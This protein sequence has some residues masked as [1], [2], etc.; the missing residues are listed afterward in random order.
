[1]KRTIFFT[2]VVFLTFFRIVYSQKIYKLEGDK[3]QLVYFGDRYKYLTPH[4]LRSFNNAMGFHEELWDYDP[5][6]V[7]VMLNDFQDY[8]N[9][10]AITMPL[11]QVIIGIGAYSFAFSIVPSSERF[12]WLFNHELTHVVMTDKPNHKDNFWRKALLG[13]VRRDEE[14]PLSAVWSYATVPRWYAPRWYQEGI[15][16]FMET[17]MSGGLGR[18]MGYYDEMYFRS[19]VHE[20]N[21]IHSV[22]GLETEG[23]ALDFQVG[24]NA[25]LYG[26]RFITYLAY[27]YGVEKL[28]DFYLRS[29]SSKAFYA[30]QFKNV[31]GKSL[32]EA[33]Q[34]WIVFE[35]DF[36]KKNISKISEY[37]ITEFTP[38]TNEPLGSM[39]T[40]RFN[41]KTGKIYAAIN[42]PGII[43]QIA[44]ID[45]YSGNIR[46]IADLDN[47]A[48]YYSTHLAYDPDSN[49]VFISE[50][51]NKYRSL[52]RIDASSGKKKTLIRF[53]RTGDLVFN[54]ADR[55]IWGVRLDNGYST[56]VK[57]PPPYSEVLP[58]FTAPFGRSIFDLD[59]SSDGKLLLAS[60][61]GI[62]GEQ[63]LV[64]FKLSELESGNQDYTSVK[65]L[66][67]NTLTQFKF[68]PDN[69]SAIGTSYYTGVS[70]IWRVDLNNGSFELLSNTETGF[71]MPFQYHPDS[72][73]VLR[74]YR[75]GMLPGRIPVKVFEDANAINFLG[76]EV[77][78]KNPRVV[79]WSLPAPKPDTTSK[80]IDQRYSPL[81]EMKLTSAWPDIAGYKNTIAAG[82]RMIWRDPISI[83]QINLFLG[84]SPW[85]T[86][87]D[88]Q[89]LHGSFSWSYWNWKLTST[90]NKTDFYDLFGP[91]KRS[92]AGYSLGLSRTRNYTLREPFKWSYNFGLYTFGD[93]EV[94]PQYQ[95][96][97]TPISNFQVATAGF[98]MSK[99]RRTLGGVDDEKG[100]KWSV[101]ASTYY[102][103]EKLF[104]SIVSNQDAGFLLPVFRNTS[105]WIRNSIGGSFSQDSSSLAY[106][107][108][109]GFRNNYVD[110]QEA[111]RYRSDI[112]FPGADI[113][114][115]KVNDYIR[116][117]GELNLQ[118]IRMRNIGATWL[119]PTFIY[120]SLFGS[121]LLTDPTGNGSRRNIFNLGF[122]TDIEV[123]MFSYM[124]TT[125]SVGYAGLFEQGYFPRGQLMLSVKLLGN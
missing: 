65:I 47:P 13:K 80:I 11:N 125:W 3:I 84:V 30:S 25:Y 91:T 73:L 1:M 101:D 99:L 108:L 87:N 54:P 35:K 50:Q 12:Q 27:S 83:S 93:L 22:I 70:N 34:E 24:A 33:W 116:T 96:I 62:R 16:C 64:M 110:W 20:N 92:R 40:F 68:A 39:S 17:W 121:H 58:R 44:E 48:L 43:S 59:I 38:I 82:Y 36:Q 46:K 120:T 57:I 98:S 124:K 79:E 78:N 113:D 63:E 90:W 31:Y 42:H 5:G 111:R 81:R 104:P 26:T 86:F 18:A 88:K 122:Q 56:L 32:H 72:L 117:M 23:T 67:D 66:E 115:I 107:Y 102:A 75:D 60:L 37:P 100:F 94:L 55:S 53:S 28:R 109:G 4:A 15:A 52:V 21:P 49:L 95:N 77:V 118:P 14:Y 2:L 19:I 7:Y 76:N 29:D 112:A 105:F 45:I 103:G 106:L 8:G 85:S 74:F 97:E 61:S 114:E 6:K 89:K 119:Y 10:G 41:P 123:V 51:T 69:Q 9:G 71:F